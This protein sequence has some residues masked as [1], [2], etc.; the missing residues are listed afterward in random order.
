[1]T[2]VWTLVVVALLYTLLYAIGEVSRKASPRIGWWGLLLFLLAP[3]MTAATGWIVMVLWNLSA[4]GLFGLPEATI[5]PAIA[6]TWLASIL[7][8]GM[9]PRATYNVDDDAS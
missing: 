4:P 7:F 5:I 1:M 6:L 3:A 2:D 9:G 8:R